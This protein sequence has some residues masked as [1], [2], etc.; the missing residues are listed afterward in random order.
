MAKTKNFADVIRNKLQANA[1]LA[2]AVNR[3]RFSASIA[4]EIYAMRKGAGLTQAELAERANTHQSVIAR[5]EDADYDGHSLAMLNRIAAA[6]DKRVEIKFV[7]LVQ[8]EGSEGLP[9]DYQEVSQTIRSLD[10]TRVFLSEYRRSFQTF[11]Q[12]RIRIS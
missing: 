8:N 4:Q 7:D 9:S 2:E 5:L 12:A 10:L 3:E 11:I 6:L 1:D